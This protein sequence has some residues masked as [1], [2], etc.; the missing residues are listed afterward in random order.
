MNRASWTNGKRR[1]AGYWSYNWASDTFYVIL[2]GCD[3]VTGQ[4]REFTVT[5]DTPEWGNWKKEKQ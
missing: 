4:Q 3:R 2:D 1:V 5:G